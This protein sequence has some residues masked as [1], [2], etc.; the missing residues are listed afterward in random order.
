MVAL[1]VRSV[2]VLFLEVPHFLVG[3]LL[4]APSM[5]EDGIMRYLGIEEVSKHE[6]LCI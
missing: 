5:R 2:H 1:F 3:N 6:G 4:L